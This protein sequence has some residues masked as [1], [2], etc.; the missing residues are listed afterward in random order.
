[1]NNKGFIG[2]IGLLLT[3]AI[4]AY[5]AY[6]VFTKYYGK[7]TGTEQNAQ[8]ALDQAGS[9]TPSQAGIDIPSQTGALDRARSILKGVSQAQKENGYN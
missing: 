3:V 4:I 8:E 5:F 7:P 9:D 1:M 2:L 6:F